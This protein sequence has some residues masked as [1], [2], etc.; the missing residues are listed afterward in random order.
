MAFMN[1]LRTISYW[2]LLGF[3]MFAGLM[4]G[5]AVRSMVPQVTLVTAPLLCPGPAEVKASWYQ[6]TSGPPRMAD[7][8]FPELP[9][10]FVV[11]PL[12]AAFYGV[13]FFVIASVAKVAAGRG[14]GNKPA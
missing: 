1:Q 2:Q 13:V 9:N 8:N 7:E 4:M 11:I 5:T 6:C 3:C 12:T 10:I 14:P